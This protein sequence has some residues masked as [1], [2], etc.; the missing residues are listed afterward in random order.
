MIVDA[1]DDVQRCTTS[2]IQITICP[3]ESHICSIERQK[4]NIFFFFFLQFRF[5]VS[6]K[7]GVL[8]R[9]RII[10]SYRFHWM[11]FK[12]ICSL[13]SLTRLA[14]N[15]TIFRRF[16]SK[17]IKINK[18]KKSKVKWNNNNQNRTEIQLCVKTNDYECK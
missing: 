11:D 10:V 14:S 12:L 4:K 6:G 5:V 7:I 17:F 18:K 2:L 13:L 15:G 8:N 3:C 16:V 1:I 9:K